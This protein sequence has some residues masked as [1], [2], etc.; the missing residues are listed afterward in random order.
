LGARRYEKVLATSTPA[1]QRLM[2]SPA[3]RRHGLLSWMNR[4]SG[5]STSAPLT[6][7]RWRPII[8][9]ANR[10]MARKKGL[11]ARLPAERMMATHKPMLIAMVASSST[12]T[13][14]PRI[15]TVA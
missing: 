10:P 9:T 13:L 2:P 5:N 14:R 11:A 3:S 7:I 12:G 8:S 4:Y 1:S 15:R 6:S